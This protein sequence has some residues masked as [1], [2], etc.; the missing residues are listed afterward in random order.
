MFADYVEWRAE[1]PSDDLMTMLLNAE[2]EDGAGETRTLTS[3][4]GPHLHL[5]PG[6]SRQRDHRPADRMAGQGARRAP[7]QR[8]QSF[9]TDPSSRT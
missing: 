4:G 1:H 2:F 6:R 3:P 8:A 9:G 5:R 7:D